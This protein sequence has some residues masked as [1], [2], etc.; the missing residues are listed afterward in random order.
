MAIEDA[1]DLALFFDPDV[2][3]EVVGYVLAAG[4]GFDVAGI[5]T[6]AHTTAAGGEFPGVSTITPVLTLAAASLPA[7]AGQGDQVS[8]ADGS[9]FR[10][11]DIQPDGSGLVR[12]ILERV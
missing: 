5:Y 11:A 4:G 2:F 6:D 10:V 1:A 8:R 7:G 12:L 9:L 3:G